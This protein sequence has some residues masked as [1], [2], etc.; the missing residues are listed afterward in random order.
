MSL[1]NRAW[2]A[3]EKARIA[4]V[5][6]E[7]STVLA[8][9]DALKEGLKDTVSS[10]AEDYEIPKRVLNKAIRSYYK[11]SIIEDRQQVSSVEEILNVAGKL[12]D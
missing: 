8:D 1:E 3:E 5:I 10:I 11:Q 4:S 7:G 2:S 12:V 9:I 6:E